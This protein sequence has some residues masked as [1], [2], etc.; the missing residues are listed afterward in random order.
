MS[1]VNQYKAI[2]QYEANRQIPVY[3]L[4]YN[5]WQI[6]HTV[7]FPLTATFQVS[8]S[9]DVGWPKALTR[10]LIS[11]YQIPATNQI[12]RLNWRNTPR[13]W[14]PMRRLALDHESDTGEVT[15]PAR[16]R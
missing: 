12:R 13:A 8:G 3:Y 16:P 9:C 7:T 1:G 6:P 10:R 15:P 5:P 11:A 4:L 2:A 14:T